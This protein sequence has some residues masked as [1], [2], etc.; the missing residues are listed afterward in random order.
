MFKDWT[1]FEKLWLAVFTAVN[2]SLFF[3]WDDTLLGLISSIAG[4]FC[5]VLVAKGKISNYYFG[6]IQASTYAYISYTYG[7][8][9]EA[10]LNA[11]FYF[12][13]Q[14]IGIYMWKRNKIRSK[15]SVVGEDVVVKRM[16]AK[17]WGVTLTA[18]IAATVL[19]AILLKTIGGRS[20]ELDSATN[21][22]SI[23]AQILMLYRFAEQWL[24][25]IAV[26]VLSIIMWLTVLISTGGNDY[27]ILVMWT[28][29]LINSIYGYINWVKMAKKQEVL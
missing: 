3:A 29:F 20:V 19:Y 21:V 27:T 4:M 24:M 8:Y 1:L 26:N 6:M 5:V 15:D 10:M 16:T 23:T 14:F 18:M 22:L 7:L 17:A 25:W 11:L 13:V 2:L 28:A 9:G 12:P